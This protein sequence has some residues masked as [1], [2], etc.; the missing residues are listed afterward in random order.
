MATAGVATASQYHYSAAHSLR[1]VGFNPC[2]K[3][4]TFASGSRKGELLL[5][6]ELA[7]NLQE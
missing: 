7:R 1:R 2:F 6:I 5:K 3:R 4:K